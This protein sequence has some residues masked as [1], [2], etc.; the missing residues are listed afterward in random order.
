MK[1]PIASRV[2]VC[3][4]SGQDQH[5]S[6]QIGQPYE[7][8]N[9]FCCEYA[10]SLGGQTEEYSIC[11][12]DGI[13]ALQLATYMVSS[14]LNNMRD[15]KNW[16]LNGEPGTGFPTEPSPPANRGTSILAE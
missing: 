4:M 7:G 8:E 1:N 2:L 10:I 3:T 16:R 5:V 12:L 9:C 14:A 6:I 15:A 11:G 13:Q